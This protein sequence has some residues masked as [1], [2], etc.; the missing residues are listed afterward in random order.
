MRKARQ[1]HCSFVTDVVWVSDSENIANIRVISEGSYETED[2]NNDCC[3]FSFAISCQ[4]QFLLVSGIWQVLMCI[5]VCFSYLAK[6]RNSYL[7][8]CTTRYSY[9][10]S[11]GLFLRGE[12]WK[13][14]F[15]VCFTPGCVT[16]LTSLPDNTWVYHSLR[17]SLQ[18]CSHACH[19]FPPGLVHFNTGTIMKLKLGHL[20]SCNSHV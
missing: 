11:A 14:C 8:A 18:D 15:E 10:L 1:A 3:K 7:T 12:I 20:Q 19:R 5:C 16:G 4:S 13:Q 6:G 9:W 2:W 17:F